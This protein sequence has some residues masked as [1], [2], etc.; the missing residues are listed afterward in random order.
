MLVG[1]DSTLRLEESVIWQCSAEVKICILFAA[2][3]KTHRREKARYCAT[4]AHRANN[5]R[6]S[7]LICVI[8][9]GGI[10]RNTPT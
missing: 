10:T 9:P 4:P 8:F 3:S 2:L 6:S 1:L 5:A 7:S